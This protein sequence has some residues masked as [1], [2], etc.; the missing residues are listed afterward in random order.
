MQ[1][2][3]LA[4]LLDIVLQRTQRSGIGSRA[5]LA[6][7]QD[8]AITKGDL[9]DPDAILADPV[10][11]RTIDFSQPAGLLLVA[12]LH[13]IPD[14]DDPRQHVAALRDALAPGSYLVISHATI[15][16]MPY[17]THLLAIAACTIGFVE[18]QTINGSEAINKPA[19]G[20]GTPLN[21]YSCESSMLKRASR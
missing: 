2:N 13:F 6:G 10:V 19:A 3:P 20:V 12:V 4:P 21:P 7:S 9:R 11:R 1:T 5:I 8:T 15:R 17:N 16:I 18:Y 14:S